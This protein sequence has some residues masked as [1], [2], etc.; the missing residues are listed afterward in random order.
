MQWN[1][2]F[3]F[4]YCHVWMVYGSVL[5]DQRGNSN[6]LFCIV[7]E[8]KKR[9]Q[10]TLETHSADS[11]CKART[12]IDIP[13]ADIF[14]TPKYSLSK[15]RDNNVWLTWTH[16]KHTEAQRIPP[17][18]YFKSIFSQKYILYFNMLTYVLLIMAVSL[19]EAQIYL[20]LLNE[21]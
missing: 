5:W 15:G 11:S 17:S 9:M 12:A 1:Y 3:H 16:R 19:L 4:L 14:L 7:N 13:G 20:H 2:L 18:R 21:C 10:A 8:F 6:P